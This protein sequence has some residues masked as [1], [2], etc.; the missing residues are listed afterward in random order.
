MI[1]QKKY[2][3]DTRPRAVVVLGPTASGKSD[4][5]VRLA[6][7]F[8]GEIISADSRQVYKGFNLTSG[9]ITKKEMRGIRHHLLDVASPSQTFSV[10]RFQALGRKALHDILRRGN[11]PII[12]GGTGLYI[13][14]LIYDY[15]FPKVKLDKKLRKELEKLSTADLFEKLRKLDQRRS[16]NIDRN[17]RVRLIRAIEIALQSSAPLP[18]LSEVFRK[19]SPYQVLKIGLNPPREILYKKIRKRLLGRLKRG[20]IKEVQGLRKT[21]SDKR[22]LAFGLEYRWITRFL[23]G[24][25]SK[26]EM[27]DSLERDIQRYTKRQLTW[28]RKDEKINWIQNQ[29]EAVKLVSRYIGDK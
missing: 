17:N 14:A 25:I 8:N 1:S 28:W 22:L 20:M 12:C 7:K 18:E 16:E 21:L 6:R 15:Q 24:E 29:K 11:L 23:L 9:K 2:E 5:A 4:L 19:S 27:T 10:T 26:K 13:D 3:T